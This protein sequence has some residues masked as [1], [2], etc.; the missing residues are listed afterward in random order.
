MLFNS[1]RHEPE[2]SVSGGHFL[3]LRSLSFTLIWGTFTPL[4]ACFCFMTCWL[5]YRKRYYITSRWNVFTIWLLKSLCGV[6]YQ[7]KGMEHLPEGPVILLSKHQ[8]AWETIFLLANMPSPLSFVLK[9]ELLYIPFFGWALGLLRMIPI[10]R[11]QGTNAF[12][13]LV[14][15]GSQRLKEG[16]W[17]I[18]FPEGT[19]IPVGEKGKYHNGGSRLAIKTGAKVV[20]IA[21]NAGE[22]WPKGSF[23]KK[24]GM[25]TVS[26]GKAI[27]PANRTPDDLTQEVED[28]IESEMRN[29]SP[30]IYR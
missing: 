13:Q 1:S 21:L 19:R 29:I 26:I 25:I 22:C 3:F 4:W 16:Q 10:D 15:K 12:R 18:I 20:P 7:I 17:I 8:S 24:P 28:W 14:R 27:S 5:P 23:I 6:Q 30:D 9:K 11:N 2:E